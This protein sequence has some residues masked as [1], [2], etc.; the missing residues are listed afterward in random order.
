MA[1]ALAVLAF[2]RG[3][4]VAR[5]ARIAEVRELA[6]ASIAALDTDPELGLLLALEAVERN[7]LPEA[8]EALHQA[9]AAQRV[10]LKL[11]AGG[12]AAT[13]VGASRIAV[14]NQDGTISVYDASGLLT[15]TFGQPGWLA[16]VPVPGDPPPRMLANDDGSI[17]AIG[18]VDG[19]LTV[20]D[21][22]TWEELWR[23]QIGDTAP[24]L[25][26]TAD[27][28]LIAA[29]AWIA[30]AGLDAA[31]AETFFPGSA[32]AVFALDSG[33][34][35]F[36]LG[37]CC[38]TGVAIIRSRS[39]DGAWLI[40]NRT[41]GNP[42]TFSTHFLRLPT[43]DVSESADVVFGA[44]HYAA[45]QNYYATLSNSTVGGVVVLRP[46]SGEIAAVYRGHQSDVLDLDID[47]TDSRAASGGA[48]GTARVW[49][50]RT[51][52][53]FFVFSGHTGGVL[54]VEF[55][56]DG[57]RLLTV[58]AEGIARIWDASNAGGAEVA[59]VPAFSVRRSRFSEVVDGRTLLSFAPSTSKLV[60]RE[61]G[62]LPE[63]KV[64]DVDIGEVVETLH[65]SAHSMALS[66]IGERLAIGRAGTINIVELE[67]SQ[68]LA[69]YG[70]PNR[71]LDS[72]FLSYS[73][74]RALI[75]LG[76]SGGEMEAWPRSAESSSCSL[77]KR[78]AGHP[79]Q[80]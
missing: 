9:I 43:G 59:S 77:I 73:P 75:A 35:M 4:Q 79:Q 51:G 24:E 16:T 30:P 65:G 42:T 26:I 54:S 13:Y 66:P 38:G 78:A 61:Y 2:V 11:P 39:L 25:A 40:L 64:L 76:S 71:D 17:L 47:K 80:C 29:R 72:V 34:L 55:S 48:D 56:S 28:T 14:L 32:G 58:G 46:E 19:F 6:G 52:V 37:D 60:M 8:Q 18:S 70:T 74:D 31:F 67:S 23:Q 53:E 45:G 44:P 69:S 5:E 50:V 57:S 20:V 27:G 62:G 36:E 15:T 21:T 10:E 41:S 63:T 68:V 22:A 49:S 33:D 12:L 7:P 3:A 1:A